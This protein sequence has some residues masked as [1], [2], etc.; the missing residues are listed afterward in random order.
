MSDSKTKL[1]QDVLALFNQFGVKPGVGQDGQLMQR[2]MNEVGDVGVPVLS[3][4]NPNM[5]MQCPL[6]NAP[7][8][9]ECGCPA[10]AQM[11]A[12]M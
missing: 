8:F 2:I 6:C 4:F 11:A 10:D 9:N 5:R 7:D 1:L 12:M 3:S